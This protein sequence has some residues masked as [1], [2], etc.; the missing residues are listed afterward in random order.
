M[1]QK[2]S[3]INDD[4][5]TDWYKP[6]R[7]FHPVENVIRIMNINDAKQEKQMKTNRPTVEIQYSKIFGYKDK[8]W[9]HIG[10]SC[11]ECGKPLKQDA[12]IKNHPNVCVGKLLNK[13]D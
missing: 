8:K 11:R 6:N 13:D 5:Y 4:Y 10:Y 12:A 7:K 2:K 3:K 1:G 9:H